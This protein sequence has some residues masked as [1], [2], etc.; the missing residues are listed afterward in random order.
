MKTFRITTWTTRADEPDVTQVV[1]AVLEATGSINK[2][3]EYEFSVA[4]NYENIS[5]DFK[6]VVKTVLTEGGLLG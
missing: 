3:E 6:A 2:K 4:G 5:D 1:V